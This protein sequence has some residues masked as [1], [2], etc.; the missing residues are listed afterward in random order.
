MNFE[1]MDLISVAIDAGGLIVAVAIPVFGGVW[2]LITSTRKYELT[3]QLRME[4]LSWYTE[5]SKIMIDIIHYIQAGIFCSESF[6]QE[7]A[8]LLSRLSAQI[9]LGRFYFPNN[10]MMGVGKEK[11]SAYQGIRHPILDY[12]HC[13]YGIAQIAD[14]ASFCEELWNLERKYTSE[15]FVVIDPRKRNENHKKYTDLK[16]R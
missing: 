1:K 6:A 11:T 13:F 5:T 9:E 2:A 10:T 16:I 12:V 7:K 14:S 8:A 15:L 3:T 4:L